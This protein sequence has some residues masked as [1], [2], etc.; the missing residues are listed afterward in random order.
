MLNKHSVASFTYVLSTTKQD[1]HMKKTD[2]FQDLFAFTYI[3]IYTFSVYPREL[4]HLCGS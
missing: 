4:Y 2:L 1:K 3:Y